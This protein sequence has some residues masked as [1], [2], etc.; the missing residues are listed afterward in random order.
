MD[1]NDLAAQ[2]TSADLNPEKVRLFAEHIARF[3]AKSG[4]RPRKIL[5][6][7]IG[8]YDDVPV[9]EFHIAKNDLANVIADLLSSP[10]INPNILINGVPA[11]E[12]YQVRVMGQP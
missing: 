3:E 2:W 8:P 6:N 11:V 12:H 4:L 7:G 10:E 9:V 1:T 5:V